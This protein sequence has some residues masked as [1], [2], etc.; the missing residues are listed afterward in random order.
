MAPLRKRFSL[1][2]TTR[3]LDHF[4]RCHGDVILRPLR[5]R[6]LILFP[7]YAERKDDPAPSFQT[8]EEQVSFNCNAELMEV[9]WMSFSKKLSAKNPISQSLSDPE[10]ITVA[11]T[12][13]LRRAFARA[14][15]A[16]AS[17]R[18]WTVFLRGR[19]IYEE[20]SAISPM[21]RHG[22]EKP[23][24]TGICVRNLLFLTVKTKLR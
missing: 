22:L 16:A 12:E 6:V 23:P 21:P 1:E 10:E 14:A 17:R 19:A 2:K 20:L 13:P 3:L 24:N 8:R 15:E 5:K 9:S 18:H 7:V 11:A 4:D